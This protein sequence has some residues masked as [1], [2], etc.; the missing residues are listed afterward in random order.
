MKKKPKLKVD[1]KQC[2]RCFNPILNKFTQRNL[3][4]D[5]VTELEKM[6]FTGAEAFEMLIALIPPARPDDFIMVGQ[7]NNAIAR[8]MVHTGLIEDESAKEP[9]KPK[10]TI[11]LS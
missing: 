11:L 3:C 10:G 9:E 7:F 2:K 5:C 4:D 6:S 8:V 1:R